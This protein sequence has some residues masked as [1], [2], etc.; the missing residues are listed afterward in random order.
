MVGINISPIF[1]IIFIKGTYQTD[2]LVLFI[3]IGDIT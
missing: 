1:Y 3:R 2:Y